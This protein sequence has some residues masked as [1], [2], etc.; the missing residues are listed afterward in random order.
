MINIG[1]YGCGNRTKQ[2]LD[3]LIHDGLYRVHAA[4][5]VVPAATEALVAQYGGIV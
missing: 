1:L 4:Y 3:S 5:D 2:L